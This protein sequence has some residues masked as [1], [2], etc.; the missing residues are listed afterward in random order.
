MAYYMENARVIPQAYEA[1]AT[2]IG[3]VTPISG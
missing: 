1:A 2:G 3:G